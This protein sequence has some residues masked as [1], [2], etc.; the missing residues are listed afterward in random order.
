MDKIIFM[1]KLVVFE[2]DT[3]SKLMKQYEANGN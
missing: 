1:N 3:F 2:F